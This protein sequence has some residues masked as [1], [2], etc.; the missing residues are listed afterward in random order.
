MIHSNNGIRTLLVTKDVC[1]RK[2]S[3]VLLKKPNIS[4]VRHSKS[5]FKSNTTITYQMSEASEKA[6]LN[7]INHLF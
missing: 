3:R 4:M 5:P 7:L 6:A 1:P 2:I